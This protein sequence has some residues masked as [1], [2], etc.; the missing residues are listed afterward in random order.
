MNTDQF[1]QQ[2]KQKYP[3]YK[4]MDD[5]ELSKKIV[6]KYPQ[7]KSSVVIPT[8]PDLV[9]DIKQ[10]GTNLTNT[11][12]TT[13][14]KQ[15]EALNAGI[16]GKQGLLRSVMQA[17]G[18]GAGGLSKAVGDV[19]TGGVKVA[20][21]QSAEQ[22]V[23]ETVGAVTKP[24]VESDFVQGIMSKYES[25][26][27]KQ[28]RDVDALLGVGSLATEFVGGGVVKRPLQ[29]GVKSVVNKV[30]NV[31]TTGI[32]NATDIVG[33]VKSPASV[34]STILDRIST[35]NVSE[36]TMASL[37]PMETFK[38]TGQDMRIT[39]GGKSKMVSELTPE[40]V[41][42]VK[43]STTKGIDS[44]TKQAEKFKVDRNVKNGS[45]VEIVGSRAD[46]ALQ[47]ADAKRQ[48]VGRKMGDIETKYAN[49]VIPLTENSTNQFTKL[50]NTLSDS[51]YGQGLKDIKPIQAMVDDFAKLNENGLTVAER[52]NFVRAYDKILR[53]AT[54][55]FG[56][57]KENASVYTE[58]SNALKSIKNET[59]DALTAKD[60]IYRGLR[61]QYA[62]HIKLQDFGDALLGKDGLLG[63]KVKG[64]AT[65][66]RAIQSN[67]DA[68]A[69]QFLGKLKEITGYDAIRDG[70]LAL[71]AMKNVGDYQGL[72][73][74]EVLNDGKSGIIKKG[75]EAV[76]DKLVGNEAQ[77]VKK[78]IKK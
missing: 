58:M 51:S 12:K 77:R 13:F 3:Q 16:E 8:E 28:K 23:K 22:S 24:V 40:E 25:L 78:F 60:K 11:A 65:V 10:T 62:E 32:N 21:P 14:A 39:V 26:D 34:T 69:R 31:L 36:A 56:N 37:N 74:L 18:I 4:D 73:L 19:V 50:Q 63:E 64:A 41:S 20:L 6:A 55:P 9:G 57:F 59:V 30:D 67:S 68:G 53:D 72:S 52:N 46:K 47:V 45:P 33:S 43:I 42:R 75:L 1:A 15:K 38:R 49:E 71:T 54:D 29:S 2:I 44:F 7:Y 70:D 66:K 35:P 5:L 76:Q 27:E 17:F 48:V 61:K